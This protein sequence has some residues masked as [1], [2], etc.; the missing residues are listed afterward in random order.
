VIVVF[1]VSLACRI[2]ASCP[3][4]GATVPSISGATGVD[5]NTLEVKPDLSSLGD[6]LPPRGGR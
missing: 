1:E 5:F 3:S 6:V 2:G 4:D